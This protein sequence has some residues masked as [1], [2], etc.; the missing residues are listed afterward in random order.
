MAFDST[1]LVSVG[2]DTLKSNY[3]QILDNTNFI[4][5]NVLQV[6]G[7]GDVILGVD[8][9][10][11]VK[12]SDYTGDLKMTNTSKILMD[13]TNGLI[14]ASGTGNIMIVPSANV[15]SGNVVGL[16]LDAT[17][18]TYILSNTSNGNT[19]MKFNGST[20]WGFQ[21]DVMWGNNASGGD[22]L[23]FNTV[24]EKYRFGEDSGDFVELQTGSLGSVLLMYDGNV[25]KVDFDT[26][27]G[28][29]FFKTSA[30]GYGIRMA[31]NALP[32]VEFVNSSGTLY[33]GGSGNDLEFDCT[34]ADFETAGSCIGVR[35]PTSS[36]ATVQ[37]A[38]NIRWNGT[39]L[40]VSNGTTWLSV[41]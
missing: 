21:D 41:H 28:T 14:Q 33:I 12:D 26:D 18:N 31:P 6:D 29:Y 22:R 17:N 1:N 38:G 39:K 30:S 37:A 36:S 9:A 32:K 11:K 2:G 34:I 4:H 13:N 5:D 16:E 24:T 20:R 40:Q 10:L 35:L 19:L 7:D 15:V 25:E 8:A 23:S 27:A 3:D